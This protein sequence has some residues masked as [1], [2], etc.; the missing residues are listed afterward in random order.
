MLSD[1]V[2]WICLLSTT[3]CNLIDRSPK[4]EDVQSAYE[5]EALVNFTTHR[6]DL[7]VRGL[8]CERISLDRFFCQ[9]GYTVT[10]QA[11][12]RVYIDAALVHRLASGKWALESGLCL[13]TL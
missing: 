12:G 4:V 7:K 1:L 10:D 11:D 2:L 13:R 8:Q 5:R 3:A 6:Q 9:V